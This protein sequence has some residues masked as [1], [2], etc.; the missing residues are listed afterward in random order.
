MY[1]DLIKSD[2]YL[3]CFSNYTSVVT[4]A[5]IAANT[6][7]NTGHLANFEALDTNY[8]CRSKTVT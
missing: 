8:R 3:A 2:L 5:A 6:Q 4:P 7:A 1:S